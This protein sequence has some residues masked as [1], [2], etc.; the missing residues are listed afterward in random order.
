MLIMF[1][2]SQATLQL[3][4]DYGMKV[5]DKA[6][7]RQPAQVQALLK[8]LQTVTRFLQQVCCHSKVGASLTLGFFCFVFFCAVLLKYNKHFS[9]KEKFNQKS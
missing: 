8:R 7:R 5:M 1:Q 9:R 4:M 2:H 3:F 6:L